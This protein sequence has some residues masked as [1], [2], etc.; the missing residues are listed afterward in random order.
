MHLRAW[1]PDV[2]IWRKIGSGSFVSL[3][4]LY[5][6]S[7]ADGMMSEHP[8]SN[9]GQQY[10]QANYPFVLDNPRVAAGTHVVYKIYVGGWGSQTITIGS[11]RNGEGTSWLPLV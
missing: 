7:A 5:G 3:A 6:G 1:V 9:I 2:D 10:E 11:H 8:A 4:R